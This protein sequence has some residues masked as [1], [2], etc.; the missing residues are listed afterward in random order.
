M[1][2]VL[3]VLVYKCS[4]CECDTTF[5]VERIKDIRKTLPYRCGYCK[6]K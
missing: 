5:K 6:E 3:D 1:T 4:K 2:L